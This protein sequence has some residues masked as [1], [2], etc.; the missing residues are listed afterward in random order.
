MPFWVMSNKASE[1]AVKALLMAGLAAAAI[2]VACSGKATQNP[3][4]NAPPAIPV[5]VIEARALPISDATEYVATLKS[6]DSAVIKA[7]V[8]NQGYHR[9][10]AITAGSHDEECLG[11]CFGLTARGRFPKH[12]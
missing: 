10:R 12:L 6:R 5:K 9:T 2:T 7:R 3:R 11:R 8:V 1:S 4:A